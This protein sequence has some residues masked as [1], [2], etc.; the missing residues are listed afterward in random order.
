M[1][2]YLTDHRKIEIFNRLNDLSRK[3][4]SSSSCNMNII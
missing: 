1:S 4:D 3:V 2:N